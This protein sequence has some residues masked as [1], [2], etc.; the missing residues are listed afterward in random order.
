MREPKSS[1]RKP[2]KADVSG[3]IRVINKNGGIRLIDEL[4]H[5]YQNEPVFTEE[6]DSMR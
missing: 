3:K 1:S 5:L 2:N 6:L 4:K